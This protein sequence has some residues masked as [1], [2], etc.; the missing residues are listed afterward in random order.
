[1]SRT[2]K[3]LGAEVL[4]LS[5]VPLRTEEGPA[6]V[7]SIIGNC[8]AGGLSQEPARAMKVALQIYGA[9]TEVTLE[10]ADFNLAR[11]V[12]QTDQ[13][14]NNLAK[15]AALSVFEEAEAV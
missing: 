14:L 9:K 8:I 5:G 11:Q 10:D 4:T 3:N 6:S 1:M 15:A 13:N 2:L 7:G 12:I